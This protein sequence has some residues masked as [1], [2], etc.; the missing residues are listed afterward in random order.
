MQD[1]DMP[2][3][4]EK[5]VSR[6]AG[7]VSFFTFLSR[8]L[9]LVRDMVLASFF[10]TGMVADAFVVAFR[11]PNLLRRL[12]AEGSLT[13]AFIPVFTEYLT[14]KSKEEA[15]E[16][17]RTVLTLLAL[18]LALVTLM[19]VVFA[20]W[21]V[22]LQA[23]GFGSS[24]AKYELTVLLTRITFPY[25]FLISIVAFF[26]GVLNSL[27]R[28]AA[29]AAA[30]IF[31]NVGI[32][33]A[34]YLI[35]PYCSEPAV[36]VAIGVI[37]GGIIQV[38]L[39]IPWVLKEGMRL[40]PLWQPGHPAVKRIG[41]LMLPAVFGSAVY[42]LNSFIGTLLASLLAQGS[43][44][45]LYFADRLVQLPLGVFAIA[46]ST[47]VLP[48]LSLQAAR[49]DLHEFG[50]TVNHALR[51][52]FF[53]TLPA[54]AGLIILGRPIIQVLFERG[55]FSPLSTQMTNHA[56]FYFALGLWAYS[57]I[58]ILLPA[59]YA[60]QDT[61][62]PV[63]VA[64][65]ALFV[66]LIAAVSLMGPLRHGGIALALSLSST[67]QFCLLLF[68]LKKK[69]RLA[70][71]KN[72]LNACLKSA[73]ASVVMGLGIYYLHSRWLVIDSNAGLLSM[74]INLAVLVV[75]G[76][77]LYFGSALALGCTELASIKEMFFPF[78]RKIKSL[79]R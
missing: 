74:T 70:N 72:V 48:S 31:L 13:I 58:R 62:T 45:S 19:G 67:L 23:F 7:V 16:M 75:A 27:R 54:T 56:L 4:E 71:L 17:A 69:I 21:L 79:S 66:N 29:P 55:D 73:F 43:V 2:E 28:F 8:I 63:K 25:I 24:G 53:I 76:I 26:M 77:I 14:K 1:S 33:G 52:V 42:Q 46:I 9:G 57:G 44:S 38:G 65:A 68:L 5:N 39:Q 36:G 47:A 78:F 64:V 60:L 6:A 15:F 34:A 40:S 20:P 51:L 49:E 11:I 35:S 37:L 32:I 10:G 30:P 3:S 22:R 41:L 18:I 59:F 61:K 50:N 12:F